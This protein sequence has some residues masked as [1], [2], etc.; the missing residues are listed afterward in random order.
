MRVMLGLITLLVACSPQVMP[1][2]TPTLDP[3]GQGREVFV[4]NCAECHGENTEGHV[5]EPAPALNASEYAWHTCTPFG[6][7]ARRGE[8]AC[9]ASVGVTPTGKLRQFIHDGKYSLNPVKIPAFKDKLS[10]EEI[11]LV[12]AYI[13]SLWTEEQRASQESMNQRSIVPTP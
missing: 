13:K 2:P 3:I 8:T 11:G 5:V 6:P 7:R 1:T 4:T 9:A 12:I 10:D